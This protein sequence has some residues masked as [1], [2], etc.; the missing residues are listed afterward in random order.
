M[1]EKMQ[2]RAIDI[3]IENKER[4]IVDK[5]FIDVFKKQCFPTDIKVLKDILRSIIDEYT[6]TDELF[7]HLDE[8]IYMHKVANHPSLNTPQ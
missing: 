7:M 2:S 4:F 1:I 3:S 5:R 6:T 8:H